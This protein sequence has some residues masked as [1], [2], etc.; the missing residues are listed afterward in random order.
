M[1]IMNWLTRRHRG[2]RDPTPTTCRKGLSPPTGVGALGEAAEQR[3]CE[4]CALRVHGFDLGAT[5]SSE[6]GIGQECAH[7]SYVRD[8]PIG[9]YLY[10]MQ[11]G[12]IQAV[13][14]G[15]SDEQIQDALDEARS[16]AVDEV[17]RRSD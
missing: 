14:A 3:L 8:T 13:C 17:L 9:T 11:D 7:C 4:S 12:L 16:E 2:P 10:A 1:A 5:D 6:L 15:A